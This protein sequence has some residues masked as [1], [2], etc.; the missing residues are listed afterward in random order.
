MEKTGVIFLSCGD[1]LPVRFVLL[2]INH[3]G[4]VVALFKELITY[5]NLLT[6]LRGPL[7]DDVVDKALGLRLDGSVF[8]LVFPLLQRFKDCLA[9]CAV[10]VSEE[11][12]RGSRPPIIKSTLGLRE[13]VKKVQQEQVNVHFDHFFG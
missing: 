10:I 8:S 12:R 4:L 9:S 2:K 5:C 3:R 13:L 1:C 11:H 7:G 6:H